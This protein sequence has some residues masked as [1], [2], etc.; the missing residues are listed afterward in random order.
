MKKILFLLS[1]I[2]YLSFVFAHEY[3]HYQNALCA[4]VEANSST[5]SSVPESTEHELFHFHATSLRHECC[6]NFVSIISNAITSQHFL[7]FK[8]DQIGQD[9]G[10]SIT[11]NLYQSLSNLRSVELL[12]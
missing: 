3:H 9:L 1:F 7:E 8:F 11:P 5:Y 12:I 4:Q 2:G 6:A 10:F